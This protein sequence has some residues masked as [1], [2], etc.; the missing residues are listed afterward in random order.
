MPPLR[1]MRCPPETATKCSRLWTIR[2][3]NSR[4]T[5]ARRSKRK[6]STRTA[7]ASASMT[8]AP[9][10]SSNFCRRSLRVLQPARFAW[11]REPAVLRRREGASG[12]LQLRRG[13][14]KCERIKT[15]RMKNGSRCPSSISSPRTRASSADRPWLCVLHHGHAHDGTIRQKSPKLLQNTTP[16]CMETMCA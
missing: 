10:A 5:C 12:R 15:K 9:G 6:I 16:S 7:A 2:G 13:R 11:I 8:L 14:R 4:A 1:E 3:W